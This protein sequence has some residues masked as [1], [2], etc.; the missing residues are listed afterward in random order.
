MSKQ[1][2]KTPVA[3]ISGLNLFE[4]TRIE[5]DQSNPKRAGSKIHAEYE[6]F[7]KCKTLGDLMKARPGHW[8]A[9][10]KFDYEHGFLK[11]DGSYIEKPIGRKGQKAQA[12]SKTK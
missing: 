10:V 3:V 1:T 8:K 4:D 9:D 11:V 2:E 12:E 6:S 5:Y 7:K